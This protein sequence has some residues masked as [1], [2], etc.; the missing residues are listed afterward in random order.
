M[1]RIIPLLLALVLGLS[2]K[3]QCP[4]QTAVDFTATDV[5][6]ETIHLFDI[7][8]RGQYVLVDFFF[9]TCGACIQTIPFMVQSYSMLGCNQHDVYYIEVDEGDSQAACLN[10]VNNHG[11][12]YP[13]ISGVNGGTAICNQYGIESFPTVILI[14]PDCSIAINDLWPISNAQ[15]IINRLGAFGIEPHDC[16]D[17]VCVEDTS[18]A[19]FS[20]SPN[21]ASDFVTLKSEGL[22]LVQVFNVLGQKVDELEANGTELNINTSSYENGIYVV[23]ASEKTLRF[24]VSH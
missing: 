6:G 17:D 3:A 24:L 13:T 1:K 4:L 22:D 10:W 9:T 23:K 20:L 18:S 11:V 7:L 14:R 12:E 2:V 8:D 5:H 21:P 15:T 16:N 19:L